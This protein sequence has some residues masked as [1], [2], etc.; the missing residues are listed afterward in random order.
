MIEVTI[1]DTENGWTEKC[2]LTDR[3]AEEFVKYNS[4]SSEDLANW[5]RPMIL[6]ARDSCHCISCCRRGEA[7][8]D[9]DDRDVGGSISGPAGSACVSILRAVP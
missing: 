1:T 4:K 6:T 7:S 8:P 2:T 9:A 5:I 3:Q